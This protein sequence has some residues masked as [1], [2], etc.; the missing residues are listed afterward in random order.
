MDNKGWRETLIWGA[1]FAKRTY[2]ARLWLLN[3]FH[4][5]RKDVPGEASRAR[6]TSGQRLEA[7]FSTNPTRAGWVGNA[8]DNSLVYGVWASG[9]RVIGRLGV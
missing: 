2:A 5:S 4:E 6:E 8:V 3:A 7:K 9:V 1:S